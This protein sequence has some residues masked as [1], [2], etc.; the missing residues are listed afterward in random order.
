MDKI[1]LKSN[2]ILRGQ[3]NAYNYVSG[4]YAGYRRHER[5]CEEQN[6]DSDQRIGKK[7]HLTYKKVFICSPFR[8]DGETDE[9]KKTCSDINI[10]MAILACD[11]AV[12]RGYLPLCPHLYFP[13]FLLDG[14]PTERELGIRFGKAWLEECDEI[15]I[16][17]D[18]I[19][20]GMEEE[21]EYAFELGKP[22]KNAYV[23]PEAVC[24]FAEMACGWNCPDYC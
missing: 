20:E 4:G 7:N 9:E 2:M 10:M 3:E 18:Y 15:W 22:M 16:V 23:P 19:T 1:I 12:E 5:C 6:H 24:A 14:D 11:N 17:G 21:I 8:P 13:L